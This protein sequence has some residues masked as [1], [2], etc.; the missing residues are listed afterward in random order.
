MAS[1][2]LTRAAQSDI[3]GILA[4]SFE[5]FGE[6]AQRRYE[7]LIS[8]AIRDAASH[9]ND[10]AHTLHPELGEGV[11]S[12][13]LMQS[14]THS[15]QGFVRRPRHFLLCRREGDTLVVGRVL[16]EAMDVHR[17]TTSHGEWE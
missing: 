6:D 3:A 9:R 16:H 10:A 13:H 7:A 12:W 2:R 1:Y 14:P 17:H 11:F 4:W 8:T 15:S 5:R